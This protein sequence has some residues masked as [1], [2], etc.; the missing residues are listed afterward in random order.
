MRFPKVFRKRSLVARAGFIVLVFVGFSL[1]WIPITDQ[2]L[3]WAVQDPTLLTRLATY[4]GSLYIGIVALALFWLTISALEVT[5]EEHREGAAHSGHGPAQAPEIRSLWGPL[6][7]FS[8][9]GLLLLGLPLVLFSGL[10]AE[11]LSIPLH[12]LSMIFGGATLV[13]LALASIALFLW[14]RREWAIV[15]AVHHRMQAENQLLE[16]RLE[17]LNQHANDIVLLVEPTG[18]IRYANDRAVAAYG[19]SQM[20]F[21]D[22]NLE[23]LQASETLDDLPEQITSALEQGSLRFETVHRRKDG[24]LFPVEVSSRSLVLEDGPCIQSIIRDISERRR[25]EE[26]LR[27]N[28]SKLELALKAA[29]MGVWT[30]DVQGNLRY[31]DERVCQLLGIDGASFAG[32]Q[33]EF[34]NV[35]EPEDRE[36][37]RAAWGKTFDE[38]LPYEVEYRVRWRDASVHFIH[39][40]GRLLRDELGRPL[41][42]NGILWDVTER[43]EAEASLKASEEQYRRLFDTMKEGFAL[44]EIITDESGKAIDYRFLEVNPAFEAMTGLA[45]ER[46]I[47]HTVLELM[48]QTEPYWIEAYGRVALL[49]EPARIE[50]YSAALGRWY[51]VFAFSPAPRQFA[52]LTSDITDRKQAELALLKS[53]RFLQEAQKVG[54]IG[55]YSLDIRTGEWESSESLDEIFGIGPTYP[56]DVQGWLQLVAP[57]ARAALGDHL[58]R[59]IRDRSHFDFDYRIFRDS[60]RAER[61]VSGLGVLELD[62]DQPVRMLGTIQD[63][64]DWKQ[65]ERELLGKT[66]LLNL[67]GS[68]AKVGGWEFD[69]KTL[70]GT[71]T[72]EVA[73]IHDLD[74]R[75]ETNVAIGVSFYTP[76]SRRRIE[77]AIAEALSAGKPYDLELE[78]LSAKGVRKDVRTVCLPVLDEHGTVCKVRGIF[79]DIT[80]HKAAEAEIQRMTE[81]LER[82]VVERTAQLE[83]TNKELEAFS[84]SVS[85]DLRGPLRGIDGFS[86]ALGEDYQDRLDETGRHYLER[87]RVGTQRMGQLID[88]LL[89]LSRVSRSELTRQE[90]DLSSLCEQVLDELTRANPDRRVECSIQPGLL[91][92]ADPRLL[93]V[94]LENLLRNAWKFTTRSE[95]ARIEVGQSSSPE[96]ERGFFIRDNG[97]GFDMVYVD[98]LFNAFQRLHAA[99]EFEGTGIGLAIVQRIIHRHGGRVWAE[100]EV[101]KGATFSFSLPARGDSC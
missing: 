32:S 37:I 88:D 80:E 55:C 15:R 93:L 47:G 20:Q 6:A 41:K 35:V 85:H 21:Q 48:P 1:F 60:D 76:E 26:A 27:A 9:V 92:Q 16:Y 65:T 96:G 29:H 51:Q 79:Q 94:V 14:R 3:G 59:V 36:V 13:F 30:W 67:T 73:R 54:R 31:F 42:V 5:R 28:E 70:K 40:R 8:A 38:N 99:E 46:W 86:R 95:Y 34:L 33:D 23:E 97:A 66:E 101:G 11:K 90:V 4:K 57:E 58:N 2:I 7:L 100:A 44:H 50:N 98:K 63:I 91:A 61:W 43:R 77:A 19:Y 71:W 52:V 82:R 18:R 83:A 10:N 39:S 53:E 75:A 12:G 17:F 22:L 81:E 49:G 45:R 89:K 87:I 74:P 78:I 64:T 25:A 72:D 84:Y 62:G 68:M 56:R 69:P 24:S